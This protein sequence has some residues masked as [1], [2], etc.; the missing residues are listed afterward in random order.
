MLYEMTYYRKASNDVPNYGIRYSIFDCW[1]R[2]DHNEVSETRKSRFFFVV[3][4]NLQLFAGYA[5]YLFMVHTE[6]RLVWAEAI[7]GL[8]RQMTND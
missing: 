4:P 8:R 1:V 2:V 3:Q 6:R 7:E 5:P